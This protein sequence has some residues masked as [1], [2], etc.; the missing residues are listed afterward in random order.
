MDFIALAFEEAV[1][2]FVE[3]AEGKSPVVVDP[4]VA[5]EVHE[6]AVLEED[7]LIDVTMADADLHAVI[8]EEIGA[9]VDLGE[10]F[11]ENRRLGIHSEADPRDGLPAEAVDEV[12]KLAGVRVEAEVRR[13]EAIVEE[14]VQFEPV[15]RGV[16]APRLEAVAD[17]DAGD[18][19]AINGVNGVEG[20]EINGAN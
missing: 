6:R 18:I 10:A 17:A 16:V 9:R 19:P 15:D 5:S 20:G 14:G 3:L 1:L 12:G 7:V 2:E 13:V 8:H 4:E 11:V